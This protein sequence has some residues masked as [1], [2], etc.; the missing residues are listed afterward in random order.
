MLI[1]HCY[2]PPILWKNLINIFNIYVAKYSKCLIF[3]SHA[4]KSI[5]QNTNLIK[6]SAKTL[7]FIMELKS[8]KQEI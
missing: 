8:L 1:H 7:L 4:T 2:M 5:G 3:V 6:F